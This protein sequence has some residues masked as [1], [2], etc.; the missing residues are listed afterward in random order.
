MRD[1]LEKGSGGGM[2]DTLGK[3]EPATWGWCTLPN[4]E[5]AVFIKF[6]KFDQIWTRSN[7]SIFTKF[8]NHGSSQ[9]WYW[10]A[11]RF[12]S[13]GLLGFNFIYF[14]FESINYIIFLLINNGLVEN[15]PPKYLLARSSRINHQRKLIAFIIDIVVGLCVTSSFQT[16]PTSMFRRSAFIM[17]IITKLYVVSLLNHCNKCA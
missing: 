2:L 7:R 8:C 14:F 15:Q 5:S 10:S 3:G 11:L 9:M 6:D 17:D 1:G 4:F 13:M 12:S 16:M